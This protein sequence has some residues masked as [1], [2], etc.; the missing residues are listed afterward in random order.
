MKKIILLVAVFTLVI[1]CKN[2]EEKQTEATEVSTETEAAFKTFK[3]EFLYMADAAV[4]KG[5]NFIYGVA[6][7]ETSKNLADKVAPVKKDPFDM[8]EVYV[9][10][11]LQNKPDG[12]EGWDEILTIKEIISIS[13]TPAEADIKIEEKKS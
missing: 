1:S 12:A 8:V 13:D 6:L 3:G 5:D 7:D 2:T 4:L 10:G 9:R 11:T